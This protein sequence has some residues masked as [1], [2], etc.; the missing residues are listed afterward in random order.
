MAAMP[1][2]PQCDDRGPLER[3]LQAFLAKNLSSTLGEKL[4]LVDT[5][6]PVPFGRIDILAKD[7]R[8]SLVVIELKLGAATRDAVGQLQSYMGALQAENPNV[9]I[10][11]VLVAASLDAGAE[12]AL[13]MARD[14][15]FMSYAV[16][17]QFTRGLESA[18]TYAEWKARMAAPTESATMK[19][20]KLWLPPSFNG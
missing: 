16:T 19:K 3:D 6:H 13:R 20:S 15:Q 8:D 1:E 14:I 9:F 17:F 10:R 18:S 2:A 5:E 4:V 7:A 11:G 12:A